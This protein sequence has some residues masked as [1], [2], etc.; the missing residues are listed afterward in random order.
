MQHSGHYEAKKQRVKHRGTWKQKELKHEGRIRWDFRRQ[1]SRG[2]FVK[3]SKKLVY[4]GP[5]NQLYKFG[6]NSFTDCI[7]A[8]QH[9][10]IYLQF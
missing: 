2:Q 5:G 7:K 9:Y 3:R 1:K 8:S 4:R 6:T 10:K